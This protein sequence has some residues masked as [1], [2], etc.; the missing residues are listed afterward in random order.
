MV[1]IICIGIKWA[2]FDIESTT[3]MTVL[4]LE[5][6]GSSITKSTLRV[7]HLTSGIGSRYNSLIRGCY[8]AFIQRY[9]SQVLTYCLTYLNIWGY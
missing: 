5:N 7:S 9:R 2:L 6:L 1:T 3:I 8:V 4:Y